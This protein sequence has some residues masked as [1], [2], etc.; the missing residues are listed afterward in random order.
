MWHA[1]GTR[2]DDLGHGIDPL[3]N[4][5][6]LP[7]DG[8]TSLAFTYEDGALA[9]CTLILWSGRLPKLAWMAE[10]SR[11]HSMCLVEQRV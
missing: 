7:F 6:R 2:G 10:V 4:N 9:G 5:A 11:E 1:T 8:G 3:F